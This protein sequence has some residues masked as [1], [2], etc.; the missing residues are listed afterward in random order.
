MIEG[1]MYAG[2]LTLNFFAS[3]SFEKENAETPFENQVI[4]S[5]NL[6]RILMMGWNNDWKSLLS[7]KTFRAVFI[8]RDHHLTK[9]L[10]YAFQE[11]FDHVF[12]QLQNQTLSLEQQRQAEIFIS[13]CLTFLPFSDLTP[14]ESMAIPQY[15]NGEW[16]LIDYKVVPIELTP[17]SGYKKLFLAEQDRVF[18]YGLEP[19]I[20]LNA[21]PHLIFM[22]TT[23]PA[24]QGFVT[25]INTDLE[26][27]ESAGK[28][29]Y[30]TGHK[31]ITHWLQ[32]QPKKV[33]VCGTSLGG[34]L[35]LL[36]A[37]DQGDQLSSV[38]ALNPP[39]LY[40]PWHRSKF[41]HWDLLEEKPPVYVLKQHEDPV[42]RFGVWKPEWHVLQVT[43]PDHKKGPNPITHHALNYA[44]FA[45]TT[46]IG[47][48]TK[49]DNEERKSRNFWLYTLGRSALYY[50]A[51]IPWR[52][53]TIPLMRFILNH[54]LQLAITTPLVALLTLL[55]SLIIPITTPIAI[56]ILLPAIVIGYLLTEVVRYVGDKM[57]A[58]NDS[59]L[60]KF[61]QEVKERSVKSL[62]ISGFALVIT[63]S[64][65]ASFILFQPLSPILTLIFAAIP[66]AYSILSTLADSLMILIGYNVV[67]PPRC[68]DPVLTTNERNESL[69][70]YKNKVEVRFSYQDLHDYYKAKREL[71]GKAFPPEE[72]KPFKNTNEFKRDVILKGQD[73]S[74]TRAEAITFFATK[75][76]IY[77][78]RHTLGLCSTELE[79]SHK[80]YVAGKPVQG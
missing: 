58:S 59:A 40:D 10:R 43:P 9:A 21:E 27:F 6:L 19:I 56:N 20:N 22:G 62:V 42:S 13:N 39:G 71:K 35:S 67:K 80:D 25:T 33:H 12:S 69:D 50:V 7:T 15:I 61:I 46:F 11:G 52:Y 54:K 66:L 34:G 4:Q 76:K 75:A 1:A 60:S 38:H 51:M 41:D 57:T 37:T 44:G 24:G 18:A 36:L 47:V 70:T 65:I 2:G 73:A 28:K 63:I 48:D 45:D 72:N 23:Y 64:F 53:L 29:L 74:P 31:N 68:H 77:D 17:T 14:Y 8:E 79:Q 5:R 16:K 78:I 55:P 26:A 3:E 30:R 49:K 32:Q